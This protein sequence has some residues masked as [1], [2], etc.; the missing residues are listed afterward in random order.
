MLDTIYTT[1]TFAIK[2]KSS[3]M[4]L[5]TF[6]FFLAQFH[7][8]YSQH[9]ERFTALVKNIKHSDSSYIENH[10]ADGSLKSKGAL[11]YY[12]M[13]EYKYS[14]RAGLWV[15]YYK[16]GEIKAES[17]YD[18]LGNL[19]SKS[20]Y[21]LEDSISSEM[22]ATLIDSDISSSKDYFLRNDEVSIIFRI[23]NYKYGVDIGETYIREMGLVKGGKRIGIWKVYTQRG[24]LEKEINYD[25]N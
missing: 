5:I 14:K 13:P 22:K 23:K 6:I 9:S 15:E 1:H 21:N 18:N 8:S 20:L 7:F 10:Y 17:F 12:D 4:K 2:L 11:L 19:L 25:D 16:N 3:T 24:R